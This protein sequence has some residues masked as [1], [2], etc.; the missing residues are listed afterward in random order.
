LPSAGFPLTGWRGARGIRIPAEAEDDL[1]FADSDAA[2][3]RTVA[4][5]SPNGACGTPM[6][7]TA[8]YFRHGAA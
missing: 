4:R 8:C 1:A 2:S 7:K 3:V 5:V 6:R